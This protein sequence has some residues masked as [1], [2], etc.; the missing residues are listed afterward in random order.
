MLT[1][2]R[3]VRK[4]FKQR[5]IHLSLPVPQRDTLRIR[6]A[7]NTWQKCTFF[8]RWR[9][10][11]TSSDCLPQPSWLAETGYWGDLSL[12]TTTP[13]SEAQNCLFVTFMWNYARPFGSWHQTSCTVLTKPFTACFSWLK[14]EDNGDQMHPQKTFPCLLH[15]PPV[16][17]TCARLGEQVIT[18]C[19]LL[20][21]SPLIRFRC[22]GTV[23][24]MQSAAQ[25]PPLWP[26]PA[27]CVH[28]LAQ[29]HMSFWSPFV[30]VST[31]K[32]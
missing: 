15:S 13:W 19:S 3:R 25:Q 32:N 21:F 16:F 28:P 20:T 12:C 6:S 4:T 24:S 11:Q 18:L 5:V 22:R 7:P 2:K 14:W 27:T 17:S 1:A 31:A 23:C 8:F 26:Y 10:L 29:T 30:V 9:Y